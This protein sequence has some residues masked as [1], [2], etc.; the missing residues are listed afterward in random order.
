MLALVSCSYYAE[1]IHL[2][3]DLAFM[4]QVLLPRVTLSDV[5]K[6]SY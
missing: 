6:F 3:I 5:Y 1:E 2:S 4:K